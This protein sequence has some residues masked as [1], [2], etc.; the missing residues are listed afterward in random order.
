M[1]LQKSI[2]IGIL[3]YQDTDITRKLFGTKLNDLEYLSQSMPKWL[4]YRE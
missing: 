3:I 2:I 4:V 1:A